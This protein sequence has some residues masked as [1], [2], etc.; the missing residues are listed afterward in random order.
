MGCAL[1][2]AE[3][4]YVA[5]LITKRRANPLDYQLLAEGQEI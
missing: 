2:A 5:D 4:L 1:R 3:E